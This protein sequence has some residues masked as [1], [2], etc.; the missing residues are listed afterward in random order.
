M[1]GGRD[2]L[3]ADRAA[4]AHPC[5]PSGGRRTARVSGGKGPRPPPSLLKPTPSG[6]LPHGDRRAHSKPGPGRPVAG[7]GRRGGRDRRQG[8]DLP[9]VAGA[10]PGAAHGGG[11]SLGDGVRG[12]G[13]H[14]APSR[15]RAAGPG[16]RG[17]AR[18]VPGRA[19]PAR[20]HARLRLARR[21]V[22]DIPARALAARVLGPAAGAR[23]GRAPGRRRVGA[24]RRPDRDRPRTSRPTASTSCCAAST[25]G[26]GAG[27]APRS[28]GCC[29]CGRRTRTRVWTVRL[30]EEPPGGRAAAMPGRPTAKWPGP[31]RSCTWRCGTGCRSRRDRG[32]VGRRAV[33]GEVRRHWS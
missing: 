11:A 7:R 24:R 20:G 13:A 9:G 31:P 22:L 18:L 15:R 3:Q 17:A 6:T 2:F 26:A 33:A 10:G 14:L 8:A 21:G 28:P 29:G 27:S 12:R 25:P 1:T 16:R 32:R 23:D 5:P 30:S 4:V 19:P